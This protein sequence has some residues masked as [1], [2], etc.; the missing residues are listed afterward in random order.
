MVWSQ[1]IPG[2]NFIT[3][4]N[5]VI[6]FIARGAARDVTWPGEGFGRL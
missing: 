5:A 3:G 6:V 1:F 2:C 4:F